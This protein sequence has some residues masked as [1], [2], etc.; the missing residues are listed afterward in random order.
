MKNIEIYKVPVAFGG[1]S[2]RH[3]SDKGEISLI[4]LYGEW[5]IMGISGDL[6]DDI[7]RY[8]TKEEAETR[9]EALL[10]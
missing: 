5:E 9:I 2:I 1:A 3:K 6:L 10:S 4:A 8:P 7:E